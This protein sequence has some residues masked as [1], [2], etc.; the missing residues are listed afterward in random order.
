MTPSRALFK[1]I[2][3]CEI[4]LKTGR[5]L[6]LLDFFQLTLIEDNLHVTIKIRINVAIESKILSSG[7]ILLAPTH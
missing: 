5:E 3:R 7:K 6:F 4:I 1:L 2:G